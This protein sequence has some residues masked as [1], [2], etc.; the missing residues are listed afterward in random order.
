MWSSIIKN[1]TREKQNQNQNKQT[2]LIVFIV[3]EYP[4]TEIHFDICMQTQINIMK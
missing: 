1:P 4:T 3:K 2:K